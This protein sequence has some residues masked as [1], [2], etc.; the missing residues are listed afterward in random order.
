MTVYEVV[1]NGQQDAEP[2]LTV[3]HYDITGSTNFQA[4]ADAIDF[5]LEAGL[6]ALVV[7]S[8]QWQG[9]TIRLDSP[10]AVGV[11]YTFTGGQVVGSH[12]ESTYFANVAANV[13]KFTDGITRPTRGRIYQGGIPSN[14]VDGDGRL[15]A[16][17]ATQLYTAWEN[18]RVIEFDTTGEAVMQIKASNPTAPNTEAYNTVARIGCA[19]ELSTQRRRNYGT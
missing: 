11:T 19:R 7:S 4:L 13:R 8:V 15:T 1:L 18:L 9:I 14:A 6:S 12:P 3:L 2:M 10:G 5:E 17:Y 16:S